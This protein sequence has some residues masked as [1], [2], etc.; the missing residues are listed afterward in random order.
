MRVSLVRSL[1]AAS[2][3]VA[4]LQSPVAGT[5]GQTSAQ[6]PPQNPPAQ[7]PPATGTTQQPPTSGQAATQEQARQQPTFRTG[8]NFVRVDVIVSDDDGNPILDLKPEEFTVLEDGKPQKIETFTVVKVDP[9]DQIEGPTNGEI[10]SPIDEE[11]EAARPEVRLFVILLD[12]YHVSRGNDMAVRKPLIDFI[13]N[14]LAPADMVAI[15][16]PLTPIN[17]IHFTRSRSRLVSAIQNFEGRKFNYQPR[18]MYEEQYMYYPAST[19]ERIRNQV[20]LSALEA[21]ATRLGGLREG[22]KSIIFVSEGLVTMLPP[23]MQEA[24]AA[25]PGLGNPNRNN[26]MAR[27]DERAEWNAQMDLASEMRQ[28]FDILNRQNTSIY[29]VDPRGLAV[30]E[31]GIQQGVGLTQDSQDL[32]MALDTL[33]VLA[34]NTD[35]RAIVNRND[36]AAGMKQ[37]M[38]DSSGYYLLGY[39]SS[40]APQDGKFHEIK[41]QVKRRNVN[42]RARKGYWA[43]TKADV[44]RA[45]APPKPEAP[46]AV[47]KALADLAVPS[48]GHAAKFWIGTGRGENG[49][50]RVTIAW[51]PGSQQGSDRKSESAARVALTAISA[52]GNPVFRGR[53][54]EGAGNTAPSA[55]PPPAIA[56][57]R[58]GMV[59]F[60]TAPGA[61]QLRMVVEGSSGEVLDSV[62]RELEVPDFTQVGVSLGTPRLYRGRTV[63]ELQTVRS[64]PSAPPAVEREF[65]RADRLLIRLDAYAPGGVAPAVT[66]KLLNRNGGAMSDITL[67][68]AGSTFEAELPLSSLAAGDYVLEFTAKAEAGTAQE[69]IAFRVGR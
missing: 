38:R 41:V 40:R 18:N 55:A 67:Q 34:N 5:R 69:T 6:Q 10:R 49:L 13:E 22:R 60:D 59:T 11:R 20:T 47:T 53:V 28:T 63:R 42:V 27:N 44:E 4:T 23:Q 2:L 3:A 25:F 62:T 39:T 36:L 35:G 14:Q 50:T 58:G 43:L 32:R 46:A 19:V 24:N 1:V 52:D 68:A 21:A 54:P 57:G 29:A 33:H 31:Y 48:R 7:P 37:I 51:E 56:R 66:G 65:S 16:Y 15:M 30:F 61:L 45:T 26:P 17:D 8:I 12:D 64:N 9:L